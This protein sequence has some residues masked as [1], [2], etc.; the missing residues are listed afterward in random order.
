[1]VDLVVDSPV[2]ADKAVAPRI[3]VAEVAVSPEQQVLEDYILD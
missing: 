1:M 3:V 2:K